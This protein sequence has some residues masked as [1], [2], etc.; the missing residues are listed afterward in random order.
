MAAAGGVGPG[1]WE[2]GQ[3][4]V[5][6]GEGH[7]DGADSWGGRPVRLGAALPAP[8]LRSALSGL[9]LEDSQ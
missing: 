3:G 6:G 4:S 1:G 5:L 9:G 2:T 8:G 7:P